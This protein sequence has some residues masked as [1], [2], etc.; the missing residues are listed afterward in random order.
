MKTNGEDLLNKYNKLASENAQLRSGLAELQFI[1]SIKDKEYQLQKLNN[2]AGNEAVSAFDNRGAE[3][4]ILQDCINNLQQQRAGAAN[5]EEV[6]LNSLNISV[7]ERHQFQDL[8]QQ[9]L[10]LQTQFADLK[11]QLEAVT[12]HNFLLQQQNAQL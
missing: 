3:L 11:C 1:A 10:C 12:A 2:T 4:E 9:Y 7:R 8:Q 5:R 6:Y